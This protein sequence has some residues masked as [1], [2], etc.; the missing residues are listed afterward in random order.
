MNLLEA[1]KEIIADK[2]LS[3]AQKKTAFIVLKVLIGGYTNIEKFHWY[4][5]QKECQLDVSIRTRVVP[6]STISTVYP[7]EVKI[8]VGIGVRGSV[9]Y[10]WIH[11]DDDVKSEEI[12]TY[13][14]IERLR[15]EVRWHKEMPEIFMKGFGL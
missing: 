1:R 4:Y 6:L 9:K 7:W 8:S 2:K 14:P 13:E 11:Y 10:C 3:L 15:S 5:S 12:K